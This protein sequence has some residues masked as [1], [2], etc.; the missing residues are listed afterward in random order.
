MFQGTCDRII[1]RGS[2]PRVWRHGSSST[3][4]SISSRFIS[5]GVETCRHPTAKAAADSVHLHGCGDMRSVRTASSRPGGSSPRV[6]RHVSGVHC[7]TTSMLVHLHGC[8]DM[9][10]SAAS[11]ASR[12]GS[13]PR[14]WRHA[15]SLQASAN[16]TRFISTGVE[17]CAPNE[18][19]R[20]S[21]SV[22]LHGCGDMLSTPLVKPRSPG[23]SPR[24]WRHGRR[25]PDGASRRR[26]IS[27]GVRHAVRHT[28][29]LLRDRFIST[30]VETCSSFVIDPSRQSGSSPRVW[31]HVRRGHADS[32]FCRFI[33]TGVETWTFSPTVRFDA[34]VHLHGCGDMWHSLNFPDAS[35][36]SSPRVWRHVS[37]VISSTPSPRFI[38]TGVETCEAKLLSLRRKAVHLHGCGDMSIEDPG[39]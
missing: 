21:N 39:G 29:S 27:T 14:V 7:I 34:L 2:S 1:S 36:G 25:I 33:S 6:W 9:A 16:P 10:P 23:S 12:S 4:R 31:R 19:S 5:T 26:F 15:G 24:V 3:A 18:A 20:R 22:H 17:T 13:S 8:G 28:I 11:A 32:T 37:S 30:G 38:S 35:V